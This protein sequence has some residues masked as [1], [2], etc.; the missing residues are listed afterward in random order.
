MKTSIEWKTVFWTNY[1]YFYS[2]I[3]LI[4]SFLIMY[5]SYNETRLTILTMILSCTVMSGYGTNIRKF[6]MKD[7]HVVLKHFRLNW[8]VSKSRR[9][10]Y[11]SES[12]SK[13]NCCVESCHTGWA[14]LLPYCRLFLSKL[15]WECAAHSFIPNLGSSQLRCTTRVIITDSP[16]NSL[17][18]T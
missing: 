1:F 9:C 12:F 18:H 17:F 5:H 15:P 10:T 8:K 11:L 13:H 4:I 16:L 7:N 2:Q 3:S 14:G 6:I